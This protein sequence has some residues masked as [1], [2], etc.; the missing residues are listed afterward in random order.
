MSKLTGFKASA[1]KIEVELGDFNPATFKAARRL[2]VSPGVSLK[3]P[4]LQQA[5]EAGVPVTGDIDLFVREAKAPLVA[6][7]GSNGKSTVVALLAHILRTAGRRI[8]VGG[9]LD[10]SSYKPALDL[11]QEDDEKDLYVLEL[12]SFQ[13]ET[14][15]RLGAEVAALLN[16]SEDH[17]DRYADIEEYAAA[18]RRIFNG[19]R[20]VVVNRD[21]PF[22]RPEPPVDVPLWEFGLGAPD[23]NSPAA[24]GL[25]LL[26]SNGDRYVAQRFEK[27]VSVSDLKL[28]GHHNITNALA[29]GTLALALGVRIEDIRKGLLT[30][31]GLP[32]RCQRVATIGGVTFYNDSK[33]TNVGATRAAVEG[34]GEQIRG[35]IIL[36]AGGVG[37]GADFSALQ[38]VVNRWGKAVV[39]IGQDAEALAAA[40]DADTARYFAPTMQEAVRTALDHATDG[41]AVL[42]SPACASFDMFDDFQQRGDTFVRAVEGLQ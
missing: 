7:T 17:M 6:V 31:G 5:I 40:L 20:A 1:P 2:V 15:E 14:T 11:L 38:T 41:D 29:A 3:T 28:F 22:S 33:A 19:C 26:E 34:L 35:H 39:L 13:L 32:H 24:G 12:S 18:K 30:F 37:K 8:G 36:I 16:L 9:N 25:G 27:I 42:L 21:D 23:I 4:A 10:G